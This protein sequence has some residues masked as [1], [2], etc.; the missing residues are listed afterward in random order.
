MLK[1]LKFV[2]ETEIFFHGL[3]CI[4]LYRYTYIEIMSTFNNFE[5]IKGISLFI[6]RSR[7]IILVIDIYIL[8]LFFFF[9]SPIFPYQHFLDGIPSIWISMLLTPFFR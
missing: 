6:S 8:Y 1:R 7:A 4:K 9:S 2:N 5:S 3:F